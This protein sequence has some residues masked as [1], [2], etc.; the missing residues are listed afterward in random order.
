MIAWSFAFCAAMSDEN[1]HS[2]TGINSPAIEKLNCFMLF[3]FG[4]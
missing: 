4:E 3:C 1:K 2:N